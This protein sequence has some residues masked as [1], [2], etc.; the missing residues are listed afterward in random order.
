MAYYL[1][2]HSYGKARVRFTKIVRDDDQHEMVDMSV[3]VELDG[4]FDAAYADSDNSLVI[5]TDTIRNMIYSFARQLDPFD[6]E[7]FTWSLGAHLVESY[8]QVATA[9]VRTST[10]P[11]QRAVAKGK[12]HPHA[13]LSG[14][15]ERWVCEALVVSGGDDDQPEGAIHSGI[16]GLSIVKTTGAGF[17]N[18]YLDDFTTLE[19]SDERIL[20]STIKATWTYNDAPEQWNAMRLRVREALIDRFV[21]G[22]SPSVQATLYAMA[23]AVLE[24]DPIIEEIAIELPYQEYEL[25]DLEPFGLEN[26]K[27]LYVPLADPQETV[28]AVLARTPP[29]DHD[30]DSV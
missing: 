1:C 6:Q 24:I 12:P 28:S 27:T 15:T 18:F 20:A 2:E 7:T 3:D 8:P 30:D 21:S 11:W 10:T 13:F 17:A 22:F 25:V 16:E 23:E 9:V 26:A 4:D 14:S 19:E 5:P 29:H